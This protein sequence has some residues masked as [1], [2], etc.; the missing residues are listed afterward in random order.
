MNITKIT[1]ENLALENSFGTI[2]R[3]NGVEMNITVRLQPNKNYGSFEMYDE[4]TGGD[5]WYAEGGLWFEGKELVEYDG[6][7][8]LSRSVIQI[9]E[10]NG[11]DASYA[12]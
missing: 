12:K 9:L 5:E 3:E 6:V 4:E 11:Y 10:E 8:S 2:R 1:N 7:F